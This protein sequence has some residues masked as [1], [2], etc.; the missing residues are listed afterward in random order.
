MVAHSLY[1]FKICLADC[2]LKWAAQRIT[3]CIWFRANALTQNPSFLLKSGASFIL[4]K[5]YEVAVLRLKK[6]TTN[7]KVEY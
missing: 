7:S 6:D 5:L 2:S 1:S 3:A 4:G